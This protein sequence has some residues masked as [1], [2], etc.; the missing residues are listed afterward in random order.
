MPGVAHELPPVHRGVVDALLLVLLRGA[1]VVLR[2]G[3][4]LARPGGKQARG[5]KS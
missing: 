1:A 2:R 3:A 5:E 4:L